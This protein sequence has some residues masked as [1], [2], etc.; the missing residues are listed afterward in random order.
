[1]KE[2]KSKKSKHVKSEVFNFLPTRLFLA[3]S[4]PF[5]QVLLSWSSPNY[6]DSICKDL[7]RFFL[8]QA[9]SRAQAPSRFLVGCAGLLHPG[10]MASVADVKH[11][12]LS[13]TLGFKFIRC[14]PNLCY[15]W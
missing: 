14:L 9:L 8:L 5:D 1:M 2:K 11:R 10:S 3:K 6:D 13:S 4:L 12:A 7:L 15:Y